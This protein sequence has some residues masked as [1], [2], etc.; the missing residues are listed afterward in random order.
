M[1][2]IKYRLLKLQTAYG[3]SWLFLIAA[4]NYIN[5]TLWKR[6]LL[7]IISILINTYT[8]DENCHSDK[9]LKMRTLPKVNERIRGEKN[10]TN[11]RCIF[12]E[13][14]RGIYS[15][16]PT[17][18]LVFTWF[19]PQKRAERRALTLTQ[20]VR[21]RTENSQSTL[22]WTHSALN[23]VQITT[24]HFNVVGITSFVIWDSGFQIGS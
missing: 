18:T 14:F 21:N 11:H 4:L 1:Y 7:G 17:L 6:L 16:N 15:P 8:F 19:K 2:V 13:V 22:H 9:Q 24:L 12:R 10:Q 5:Y 20:G 3:F 23:S